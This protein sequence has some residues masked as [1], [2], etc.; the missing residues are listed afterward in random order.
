[1]GKKEKQR[2]ES[3]NER[4]TSQTYRD[5]DLSARSA[6]QLRLTSSSE[7]TN[8]KRCVSATE[9]PLQLGTKN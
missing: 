4:A 3:A 1:M 8:C 6:R 9:A 2:P 7:A 5:L